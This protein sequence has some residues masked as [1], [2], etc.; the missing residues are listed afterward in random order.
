M[1]DPI[2]Q[3]STR[4]MANLTLSEKTS[5][6]CYQ[7]RHE[8]DLPFEGELVENVLKPDQNANK[9]IDCITRQTIGQ[10]TFHKSGPKGME[11]P[12]PTKRRTRVHQKRQHIRRSV[13]KPFVVSPSW[14]AHTTPPRSR[15]EE[16]HQPRSQRT[17]HGHVNLRIR[18]H[19]H[20]RA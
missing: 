9:S 6:R 16:E 11:E 4:D 13:I 17:G 10:I 3:H 2:K 19:E 12:K 1:K 18:Q 20:E 15:T 8:R 14:M 5:L 7:M